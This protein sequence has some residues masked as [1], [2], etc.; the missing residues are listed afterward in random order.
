MT[1]VGG[2]IPVLRNG[3]VVGAVGVSGGS[4][5]QDVDVAKAM[6]DKTADR[7]PRTERVVLKVTKQLTNDEGRMTKGRTKQA[8]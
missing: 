8:P 4:V 5:A 6:V 2:G 7:R 3:V 1:L